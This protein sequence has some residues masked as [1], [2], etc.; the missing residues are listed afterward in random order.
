V[1]GNPR[2]ELPSAGLAGRGD[3]LG[4]IPP[5]PRIP[6]EVDDGLFG[7]N[8]P[9]APNWRKMP[10]QN[11]S[12]AVANPHAFR[13]KDRAAGKMRIPADDQIVEGDARPHVSCNSRGGN[14]RLESEGDL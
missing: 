12:P 6:L 10:F 4:D 13:A 5:A 8:V 9:H 14:V 3:H 2:G 11:L 1:N 7:D